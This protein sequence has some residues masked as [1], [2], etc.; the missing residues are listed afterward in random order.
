MGYKLFSLKKCRFWSVAIL[1]FMMVVLGVVVV[2][3]L[4]FSTESFP[5]VSVKKIAQKNLAQHY[6]IDVEYPVLSGMSDLKI[7]KIINLDIFDAVSK[8]QNGF[9]QDAAQT[10]SYNIDDEN[11]LLVRYETFALSRRVASFEIDVSE[12]TVGAAHP[13]DFIET[14]N[15]DLSNGH[16]LALGDIFHPQSSY[17]SRIS[18]ISVANLSQQLGQQGLSDWRQEGARPVAENY[19]NFVLTDNALVIIFNPYQVAP[20][21]AGILQVIIPYAQLKNII[22]VGRLFER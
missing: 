8:I 2:C 17:L 11:T 21:A 7:Q 18:E 1:I 13:G 16:L 19:Q 12:Y 4:Y 5:E 22:N 3:L 15:Y 9:I 20:S 10:N 6:S 14:L